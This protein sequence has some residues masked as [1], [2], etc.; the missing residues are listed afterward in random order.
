MS[1]KRKS[2]IYD[3]PE[4]YF[5]LFYPEPHQKDWVFNN[6]SELFP[7]GIKNLM[8]PACG[9]GTWIYSIPSDY[10]L[11]IDINPNMVKWSTD[12]L[13]NR[14]GDIK[15]GNMLYTK[16][17]T[18]KKFD[19]IINPESTIGHLENLAEI[20]THLDSVRQVIK[21]DGFYFLGMPL[22]N[23]FF[24]EEVVNSEYQSE[25]KKLSTGGRGKMKMWH[26]VN[27]NDSEQLITHYSV[28]IENNEIY[29][30]RIA[31]DFDIRSFNSN[32]V[33]DLIGLC[34]FELYK[35]NYMQFP[36]YPSSMN[37]HDLGLTSLILKPV[38]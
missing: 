11:G 25:W 30:S 23:N 22:K 6:I 3:F 24:Q 38:M 35:V 9:S 28:E 17:Y 18:N 14:N 19:L 20:K 12:K 1:K 2:N 16:D 10:Y 8:D 26:S 33:Q 32:E 21:D 36:E 7:G 34:G 37:L 31:G 13:Q 5:D 29:P 4:L 15:Q 27:L